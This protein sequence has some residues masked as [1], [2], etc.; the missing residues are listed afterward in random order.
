[1]S[2]IE[3]IFCWGFNVGHKGIVSETTILLVRKFICKVVAL[4]PLALNPKLQTEV[5]G[6]MWHSKIGIWIEKLEANEFWYFY[7]SLIYKFCTESC[8]DT[9]THTHH[10]TYVRRRMHTRRCTYIHR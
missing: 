10:R 2:N 8:K 1:M 4:A 3:Y 9:V 5:S 6:M 7:T